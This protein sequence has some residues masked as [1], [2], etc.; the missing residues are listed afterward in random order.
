MNDLT[1][2]DARDMLQGIFEEQRELTDEEMQAY[3]D[4][5]RRKEKDMTRKEAIQYLI[6]PVATST[7]IGEEKQ[8]EFEA[9]EMAKEALKDVKKLKRRWN[10]M[11]KAMEKLYDEA[12]ANARGYSNPYSPENYQYWMGK[13]TAMYELKEVYYTMVEE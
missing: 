8:K 2:D 3:K 6:K 4:M 5:L 13:A 10:T 1:R 9:Y 7:E 11:F 12:M